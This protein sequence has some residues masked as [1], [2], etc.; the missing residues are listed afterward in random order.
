MKRFAKSI[1][2]V[3]GLVGVLVVVAVLNTG[4]FWIMNGSPTTPHLNGRWWAGY[5]ETTYLGRQWCVARFYRS[6][7]GKSEMMLLSPSGSPQI[8]EVKQDTSDKYF[9]RLRLSGT[10][11]VGGHKVDGEIEGKQLYEG[12][13]Y[14]FQRLMV[15]R[16]TDFWKENDDIKIEGYLA[17][18]SSARFFGIE[19]ISDEKLKAFW[20]SYVRPQQPTPSPDDIL[21]AEG[22]RE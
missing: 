22:V 10:G 11:E 2:G 21:A 6:D 9:V 7:S 8:F 4:W 3:L 12:A 15:G 20:R 17:P 1:L 13:R 14:P 5:Y 16:F 19:P 18:Q